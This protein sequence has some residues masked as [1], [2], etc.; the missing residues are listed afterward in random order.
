MRE[1]AEFRIPESNAKGFLN[2][3][4]GTSVTSSVRK[5]VI[6]TNSERFREIGL[7]DAQWK[8]NGRAF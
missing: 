1:C 7:I 6:N 8:S 3:N 2:D 4:E 5:L